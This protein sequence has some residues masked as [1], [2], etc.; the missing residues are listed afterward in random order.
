MKCLF[1]D[2][3]KTAGSESPTRIICFQHPFENLKN[4]ADSWPCFELQHFCIY[5]MRHIGSINKQAAYL[6]NDL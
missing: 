6:I 3:W 5:R 1:S 4:T 2:A